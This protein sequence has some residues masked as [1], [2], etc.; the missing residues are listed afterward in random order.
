MMLRQERFNFQ[1]RL[2]R[3]KTP[4]HTSLGDHICNSLMFKLSFEIL[5]FAK[6]CWQVLLDAGDE[7]A[8]EEVNLE[9]PPNTF[10]P[11][12]F[13]KFSVCCVRMVCMQRNHSQGRM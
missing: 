13:R 10:L 1:P 11:G 7:C 2:C 8:L 4:L 9:I 3:D 5:T 6:M 12:Q